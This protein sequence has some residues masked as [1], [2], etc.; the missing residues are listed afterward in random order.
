MVARTGIEPVFMLNSKMLILNELVFRENFDNK[1]HLRFSKPRDHLLCRLELEM[2]LEKR[3]GLEQLLFQGWGE[4]NLVPVALQQSSL[5]R[6]P[7][8]A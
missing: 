6:T 1:S 4:K 5:T 3:I 7:K 8:S 2:D